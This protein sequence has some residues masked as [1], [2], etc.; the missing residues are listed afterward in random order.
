MSARNKNAE[1]IIDRQ[2]INDA[3]ILPVQEINNLQ[4]YALTRESWEKEIKNG[5]YSRKLWTWSM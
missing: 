4:I 1:A 5:R 2:E 3:L